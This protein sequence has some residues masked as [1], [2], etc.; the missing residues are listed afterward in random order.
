MM[1][2]RQKLSHLAARTA[3]V[4]A[5]LAL[6]AARAEESLAARLSENG[7]V[8]MAAT[9]NTPPVQATVG[10][11]TRDV[12]RIPAS[13]PSFSLSV[14]GSGR[15]MIAPGQLPA[16][17]PD[18]LGWRI[19]C[20]FSGDARK[21][22]GIEFVHR[23]WLDKPRQ[24]GPPGQRTPEARI[25][26]REALSAQTTHSFQ[27]DPLPAQARLSAHYALLDDW[28]TDANAGAVFSI[29]L[30]IEDGAPVVLFSNDL[31][32]GSQ[33]VVE[34]WGEI[35]L[36]L[37]AYA[38]KRATLTLST[39][40]LP[41]APAPNLAYPLWGDVVLYTS[42]PPATRP[43]PSVILISLD[44]LRADRLG[45]YGYARPTSPN[46][47]AFAADAILFERAL[48]PAP[49]TTPAHAS[50]FTGVSPYLHRAGIYTE[51]FAL[52]TRWAP[53]A[54]LLAARG[55]RT[56]A[57]TE[58]IAIAG[59]W[60]FARGFQSY[61]DGPSPQSHVRF[62]VEE[63]FENSAA[64]LKRFG[65]LPFFLF[66]HT[67]QLHDP[68]ESPPPYLARFTDPKYDGDQ[69][70][71]PLYAITPEEKQNASD[72]YD[73]GIAYTDA[74]FGEFVAELKASGLYDTT[75]IIV[76]SDHGEEFWE[77]GGWGHARTLYNEVLNVPLLIRPP[78]GVHGGKRVSTPVLTSDLFATLLGV[79]GAPMPEGRDSIDLLPLAAASPAPYAREA[80]HGYFRG[81]E[82][83]KPPANQ[84]KEWEIFS[85]RTP[86]FSYIATAP[87]PP[88]SGPG[89]T[90][91]KEELFSRDDDP[92]EA[93]DLAAERQEDVAA[94]RAASQKARALDDAQRA[95]QPSP[96]NDLD[97]EQV[98]RLKGLGYF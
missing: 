24:I 8:P 30:A 93:R 21:R 90:P 3:L 76:T 97:Q 25:E 74:T 6:G 23:D 44:T 35:D 89:A 79:T 48:S 47:D 9:F 88:F 59:Y 68:Y 62:I 75:W 14:D 40:D 2:H 32:I 64:W 13:G 63:T 12:F 61:S 81:F 69:M 42:T 15:V 7:F 57:E 4:L 38:G 17:A 72:R 53:I 11:V 20:Q 43:G 98:D 71:S 31:D 27:M 77:H 46:L 16:C 55:Y 45:C 84:S 85:V 82:E 91:A 33:A 10:G 22:K 94:G 78:K 73:A 65:Q 54:E 41:G 86:A 87:N 70:P 28:R 5:L 96:R 67:Y 26:T 80:I 52:S 50:I 18:S 58:G 66:V 56:H 49:M 83:P 92:K 36:D 34:N 29:T 1:Q 60:G 51:G 39:S 37:A 95:A 19:M